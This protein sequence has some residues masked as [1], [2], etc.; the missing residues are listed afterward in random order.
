MKVPV[1]LRMP[2]E[3]RAEVVHM[4]VPVLVEQAL[5][6]SMGLV[7]MMLASRLSEYAAAP[8]GMVDAVHTLFVLFFTSLGAGATVVV[9]QHTGRGETRVANEAARQSMVTAIIVSVVLVGIL[10]FTG[11][12]LLHLLYGQQQDDIAMGLSQYLYPSLFSYPVLAIVTVG[13]GVLRG[14]GD[15]RTPMVITVFMGVLNTVLA[16]VLIYGLQL[17]VLRIPGLGIAGAA[18]ALLVSRAIGAVL[19]LYVL[20]KGQ[21]SVRMTLRGFRFQLP[22]QRELFAIG[23]PVTAE[24]VLF[25]VGKLIT[26][27]IVVASGPQHTTAMVIAN[28]IFV[29]ICLPGNAFSIAAM[30]IVGQ[31]IGRGQHDDA[32]ERLLYVNA[33]SCL[34][35]LLTCVAMMVFAY[36]LIGL[37][38]TNNEVAA[39]VYR[40][41]VLCIIFMPTSWSFSFVLSAG[42]KGAGDTKYSLITTI[43]GMWLFR[44]LFGYVLGIVFHMGAVGIW[45]A[46][47]IDWVVRGILYAIRLRGNRWFRNALPPREEPAEAEG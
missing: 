8:I 22:M 18:W 20:L 5:I 32:R 17:G 26:Q 34:G 25:Q 16:W 12:P 43:I 47:C 30:P 33:L 11:M 38:T 23:L 24:N 29:F 39:I 41:L 7:G 14:A 2:R 3:V 46:M 6:S 37:F 15:M 44:V 31:S 19:V 42:L 27:V 4:T 40:M 21:R 10:S 13:C 45:L 36:P 9:A 1:L 28:S 35:L